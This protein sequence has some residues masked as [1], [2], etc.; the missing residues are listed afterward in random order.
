[1]DFVKQPYRV[2]H[3]ICINCTLSVQSHAKKKG[4]TRKRLSLQHL[5][6]VG[7]YATKTNVFLFLLGIEKTGR[8]KLR[9]WNNTVG[10]S[11]KYIV[12]LHYNQRITNTVTYNG[13]LLK[14]N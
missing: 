1:M 14:Y 9:T 13:K 4:N 2:F 12:R 11:K 3:T 10:T 7:D 8:E 5:V 6:G